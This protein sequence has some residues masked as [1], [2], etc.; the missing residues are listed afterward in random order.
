MATQHFDARLISLKLS[1]LSSLVSHYHLFFFLLMRKKLFSLSQNNP[2]T[3]LPPPIPQAISGSAIPLHSAVVNFNFAFPKPI[4]L[5]PSDLFYPIPPTITQTHT[6]PF[7]PSPP[8]PPF[9]GLGSPYRRARTVFTF[10]VGALVLLPDTSRCPANH[11][12][13]KSFQPTRRG[14][15][16]A[17]WELLSAIKPLLLQPPPPST[18]CKQ[19]DDAP[20]VIE[21]LSILRFKKDGM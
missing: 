10:R 13:A 16:S 12:L 14:T 2:L 15:Y 9:H 19:G 5:S 20:P 18:S 8:L 4:R 11:A 17:S 6:S 1:S 7:P 3:P 21:G